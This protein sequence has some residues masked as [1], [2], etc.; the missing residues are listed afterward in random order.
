MINIDKSRI[1]FRQKLPK[2]IY[3]FSYLISYWINVDLEPMKLGFGS[4]SS[5]HASKWPNQV[6]QCLKKEQ[7][8]KD[9][10]RKPKVHPVK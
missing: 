3:V 6:D 8:F 5:V 1:W 2:V 9:L 7:N 10:D 4:D